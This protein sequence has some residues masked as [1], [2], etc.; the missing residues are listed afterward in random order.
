[1]TDNVRPCLGFLGVGWIGRH[2]MER[3][4]ES[5]VAEVA[6]I[7]DA[8]PDLARQAAELAP[9]AQCVAD[10]DAL[11]KLDLDGVVIA[12]PSALHAEQSIQALRQ[13][14]AVFCQK[15]V[16][17]S[18]AETAAV[19]QAA[20]QADRLLG[21]DFSYRYVEGVRRIRELVQ[22]GELGEVYAVN[23]VFHNAY[24]PDKPW[25]YDRRL[26]GGGCVIDL[27]IHLIDL[28][29]WALDFPELVAADGRCFSK[30]QPMRAGGSAVED[31][32][33]ARLQLGN[34]ACVDLSCSWHVS[35]GCDAVIE[36]NFYGSQGGAA[37]KNVNGSF[38]DFEAWRFRGTQ[39]ELLVAPPDEW[40]GRAGV[41]WAQQLAEN[42]RFDPEVARVIEVARA[43]D[44]IYRSGTAADAAVTAERQ[45]V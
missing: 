32:A 16:G 37:L 25:F 42:P 24:G 45:V 22:S 20:R 21:I 36:A 41:A 31:Y 38:Y 27:G 13:G 19:V 14:V 8:S 44:G 11:L 39:R 43:I 12:T 30:G 23:L 40:G 34:G 6:G 10:L 28:A 1:M 5:G 33:S 4:I 35:A 3:I 26:S 7:A 15:P 17:R 18:E 2:R 29:L 9:G